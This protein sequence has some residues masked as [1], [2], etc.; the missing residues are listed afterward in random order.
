MKTYKA[1]EDLIDVLI[2]HGFIETTP[3]YDLGR[4]KKEF[5]LSKTSQKKI[6]FDY[7]NIHIFK[8]SWGQDQ[9]MRITE[10]D[11]KCILFYFKTNYN[12]YREVD[13]D[14]KFKFENVKNKIASMKRELELLVE[15]NTKTTRMGKLKRIIETY[16]NILN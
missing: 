1:N 12:D 5:R 2:S 13:K 3:K 15:F 6:Y 16:E 9:K 4:R 8:S 11:L 7:E 14:G 10:D